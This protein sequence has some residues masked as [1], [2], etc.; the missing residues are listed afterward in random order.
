[1]VSRVDLLSLEEPVVRR[2]EEISNA[3]EDEEAEAQLASDGA[4]SAS[5]RGVR[6]TKGKRSIPTGLANFVNDYY[7]S[8]DNDIETPFFPSSVRR[9]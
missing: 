6:T 9:Q 8:V 3:M 2:L 7:G 5:E 4:P 1:M